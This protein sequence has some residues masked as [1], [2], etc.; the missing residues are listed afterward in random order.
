MMA[1]SAAV[2]S[3][4]VPLIMPMAS[5]GCAPSASR[6][7]MILLTIVAFSRNVAL[8]HLS[9]DFWRH[10][11]DLAKVAERARKTCAKLLSDAVS[12]P[13]AGASLEPP[14]VP[15]VTNDTA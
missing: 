15:L 4:R 7:D 14:P 11:V 10:R 5:P 8:I 13:I 2:H 12:D 6:P 9:P 1:Q 3:Q